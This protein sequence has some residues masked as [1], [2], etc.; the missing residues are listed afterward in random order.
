LRTC[1]QT[2]ASGRVT[3]EF[4]APFRMFPAVTETD[5]LHLVLVLLVRAD[6]PDAQVRMH[7]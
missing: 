7:N 2:N 6:M 5:A 3:A 1:H 4:R